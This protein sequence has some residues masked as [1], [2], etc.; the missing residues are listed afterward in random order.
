MAGWPQRVDREV[1]MRVQVRFSLVALI[2]CAITAGVTPA[3][4]AVEPP[5]FGVE[6][7]FAS[8]CNAAHETCGE[9]AEG[10][11]TVKEAEEAG[12]QQ[13]GA[14]V[15]FGVSDFVIKSEEKGGIKFPVGYP[16]GSVTSA[17]F[18]AGL[19]VV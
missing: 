4:Q 12:E 9:G 16:F 2:A 13:A 7:L 11:K 18:D 1:G 3:A 5:T 15:P 14:F 6:R 19:G 17:R 8:N 10:A